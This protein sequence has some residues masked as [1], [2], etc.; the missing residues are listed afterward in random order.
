MAS[1]KFVEVP[2]INKKQVKTSA[3]AATDY[4][5]YTQKQHI[6]EVTDTYIGSDEQMPRNEW[7]FNF[8]TG[9]MEFQEITLPQGVERLFLEII[10]NAGDNADRSWRCGAD[11]ES[12]DVSVD[13]NRIIIRNGGTPIPIE[14]HPEKNIWVPQ[15]IFGTLLTSSNYDKN[16][17]RMGCGRNGY[18]AKL[19]NIFSKIF[20]VEVGDAIR[21]LKYQQTW[22]NNMDICQEPIITS[23][24]GPSYVQITYDLDFSRFKYNEYPDEAINLFAR[25]TLDFSFTCKVPVIFNGVRYELMNIRDYAS[26]FFNDVNSDNSIIHYEWPLGTEIKR[27]RG[28]MVAVNDKTIP[29]IEMCIID[30]PDSGNVISFVNGIM[31]VDGGVHVDAAQKA[32]AN[33]LLEVINGDKKQKG[34][35][36]EDKSIKLNI[37]DV[38]PHM[39]IIMSCRLPDPKYKSQTKTI[40]ASPTP[41]I[42]IPD[43]TLAPIMYW[44][45]VERLYAA[46]EAKQFKLLSKNDGK[47]KKHI[48]LLKGDDANEAGGPKSSECTLMI[49]EGLSAMGYARV[50]QSL[51]PNGRDIIGILPLKGKPLNVLNASFSQYNE[52]TEI[53]ELKK[54]LGLQEGIDY[55]IPENRTLLRYGHVLIAADQDNDGHHIKSLLMLMFSARYPSL[56]SIG[57][58]M[59]LN[60]PILRLYKGSQTIKFFSKTAYEKW[61][62]NTADISDWKHKYYKGLGTSKKDDIKDDF[63]SPRYVTCYYDDKTTDALR[64]AF[65]MRLANARKEW[66]TQWKEKLDIDDV[67]MQPISQFIFHEL[68]N[69]S[70]ENLSRSIPKLLDGMKESQ[71]KVLWASFKK[72]ASESK[73]SII[74]NNPQELKVERFAQ[75]A[76]EITNYHHGGKILEDVIKSMAQDF[77]GANNLPYFQRDGIM[78]TRNRGGQDSADGRY[79]ETRPE[80]WIGYV[81]KREDMPL[82]EYVEEEGEYYEPISLLPIIPMQLINGAMGVATGFSTY[83]P[84][85][86]PVSICEWIK[87]RINN[88]PLPDIMPWYNHFKGE[89]KLSTR[90]IKTPIR[91]NPPTDDPDDIARQVE[92]EG[93]EEEVAVEGTERLSMVCSG[94]FEEIDHKSLVITEL[95]VG[96]WTDDYKKWLQH[97]LEER[98][99]TDFRDLSTDDSVK[100]ELRGFHLPS[101]KKLRLLRT[102][103]L[104]NM[105]LLDNNNRPV[106][107]KTTQDILETFYQERLPYYEKRRQNIIDSYTEEI[108]K[109]N[110]RIDFVQ[111][112]VDGKLIVMNRKKSEIIQDIINLGLKE[113]LYKKIKTSCYSLDEINEIKSAIDKLVK[114]R[115]IIIETKATTMWIRDLELFEQE[116]CRRYKKPLPPSMQV[117]SLKI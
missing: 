7:I 20:I 40:L 109:L 68:I 62:Q 96:R 59:Y 89:I 24:D 47:K 91:P 3:M 117:M 61:K 53:I 35:K 54:M 15:M 14:I 64:L 39:S 27:Q 55:S 32:I 16:V 102:Y 30:A 63:V 31:T 98:V 106:K 90:E 75:Y 101:L 77:V 105:V 19:V 17:V 33:S 50:V 6:Y 69:Y 95:P 81:Y 10:S 52:N 66:I 23:Y 73:S 1:F 92:V 112:V 18:G 11:P 56:I 108:S 25:F 46:L 4:Q 34:K 36:P 9:K 78:G 94:I 82:L 58:L 65:D 76:S 57:M 116:Y 37:N 97:L 48:K 103:G 113:E 51:F 2:Q 22:I 28:A 80:W 5:Q 29:I 115:Q 85:H 8:E 104:T 67:K 21:K 49:V 70:V 71:R 43:E 93:E 13:K 114:E 86:Y 100:F 38:K 72:W 74:K 83:I 42:I 12:I 111:A 79:V 60:T 110:E 41:K 107:Y 88:Q 26:L 87:A 45:M 99:I 84:N 44:S